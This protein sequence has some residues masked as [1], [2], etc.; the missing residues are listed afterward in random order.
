VSQSEILPSSGTD[1]TTTPVPL[2]KPHAGI[3]V[4]RLTALFVGERLFVSHLYESPQE[5]VVEG[6][7]YRWWVYLEAINSMVYLKCG[8]T[9]REGSRRLALWVMG[10]R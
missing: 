1:G 3:H 6:V 4:D 10:V 8:I 2:P 7:K 5:M 9:E